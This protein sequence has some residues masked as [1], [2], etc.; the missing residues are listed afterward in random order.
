V[1]RAFRPSL[2]VTVLAMVTLGGALTLALVP[3][4]LQ[5]V[6]GES[7][8]WSRLSN[9]ATT[10][11]AASALLSILALTGVAISLVY[12]A[13]EAKASREQALRTMHADLLKM[14][15]EDELY[16]RCWGPD[17]SSDD[18]DEQRA[19][20]YIN[21]IVSHWQLMY[22]LEAITVEHLR[23]LSYMMF[24]GP[25]GSQFWTDSRV[26]RFRSAGSSREREMYKILDEEYER[27]R[28]Q[29]SP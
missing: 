27:A 22:E 7:R 2:L 23:L 3:L 14:A 12:Q 25:L 13:R 17:Y 18:P 9:I 21:L 20:L 24:L 26:A 28:A 11:S 15:M 6:S 16:R 1:R 4:I 5:A 10:Y 19:Q 8:D 29:P